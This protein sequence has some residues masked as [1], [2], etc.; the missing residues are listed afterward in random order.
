MTVLVTVSDTVSATAWV[1]SSDA[2]SAE[3]NAAARRRISPTAD[4][5]AGS[6]QAAPD[7]VDARTHLTLAAYRDE[8]EPTKTSPR[9]CFEAYGSVAPAPAPPLLCNETDSG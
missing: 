8:R 4:G 3:A 7:P 5:T 1:I 2:P 6:V 9:R